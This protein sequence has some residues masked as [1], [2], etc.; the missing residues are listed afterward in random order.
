MTRLFELEP[1]SVIP[2][3]SY[4]LQGLFVYWCTNNCISLVQTGVLKNENVRK[5]LD[6]PKPPA[7]EN[8]PNLQIKNPFAAVQEV[9]TQCGL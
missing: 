2:D 4:F 6:I 8:T 5:T 9:S 3:C 1:N 7:P